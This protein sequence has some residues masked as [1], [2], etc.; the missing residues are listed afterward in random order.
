VTAGVFQ[1]VTAE[2]RKKVDEIFNNDPPAEST[3]DTE[4]APKAL[5]D[6]MIT[7]SVTG[8]E[9]RGAVSKRGYYTFDTPIANYDPGFIDGCLVGAW[10][11]I[12]DFINKMRRG[13]A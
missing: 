10:E 11:L 3:L 13:E 6:M 2:E 4:G 5:A 7:N 12:F 9:I 1:P 8:V